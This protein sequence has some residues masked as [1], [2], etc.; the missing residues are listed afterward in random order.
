MSKISRALKRAQRIKDDFMGRNPGPS[1]V[2]G[3]QSERRFNEMASSICRHGS[4]RWFQGLAKADASE[5]HV[6]K[7]DFKMRVITTGP[8]SHI[9]EFYIRIQIKSSFNQAK[10]F[11]R[12]NPDDSIHLVVMHPG[13]TESKLKRV[14]QSVYYKEIARRNRNISLLAKS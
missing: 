9:C 14:L 7:T 8:D 2:I 3:D 6:K 10:E 1:D 11:R 13:M 12:K 4:F 5:D